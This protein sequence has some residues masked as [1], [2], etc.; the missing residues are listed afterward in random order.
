MKRSISALFALFC[1]AGHSSGQPMPAKALPVDEVIRRAVATETEFVSEFSKFRP[2]IETYLQ[3][4]DGDGQ[5]HVSDDAYFIGRLDS[6]KG[7]EFD[8]FIPEKSSGFRPLRF[9]K[10]SDTFRL[11]PRGFAQMTMI[12]PQNFDE[13]HYDFHDAH[14]EFVGEV[15]CIAFDVNPKEKDSEG[16]FIGRI[17]VEDQGF[18]VVRY[19]GTYT[20]RKEVRYLHFNAYRQQMGPGLQWLPSMIYVEESFKGLKRRKGLPQALKAHVRLWAYGS[21]EQWKPDTF[22]NIVVKSPGTPQDQSSGEVS[23]TEAVREWQYQAEENTLRR[24][25]KAGL[26]GP[27][28][29]IEVM[30]NTVLNNLVVTN[31]VRM[32]PPPRC[33]V[34][35]TTPFDSGTVGHSILVSRGLIDVLPNEA[36]LAAVIARE[37]AAMMSRNSMETMNAFNDRMLFDDNSIFQH[38][39]FRRSDKEELEANRRA[40]ALLQ[41][42]PYKDQ[43][44]SVGL[45]L[46]ALSHQM[47]SLTNLLKPLIGNPIAEN[48]QLLLVA[49][50]AKSAPPLDPADLKQIPALPLASRLRIVPWENRTELVNAKPVAILYP[51]EKLPFEITPLIL[52]LKRQ[53]V[54]VENKQKVQ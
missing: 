50:L 27:E 1:V 26:L 15:S 3:F 40:I 25:E 5:L 34:L 53:M 8:N 43:L 48:A 52:P 18:H 31:K 39:V 2:I 51:D 38:F 20:S 21:S 42:S 24:M 11:L 29:E 28:G 32:D 13:A 10:K 16:R 12:D 49:D 54:V 47:P 35:L 17:W 7:L 6:S 30:L 22:T 23:R 37:L 4:F 9:L 41:N 44:P 36:S 19:S 45:F 46:V 33:R 14:G